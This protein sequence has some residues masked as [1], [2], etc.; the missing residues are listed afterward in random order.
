MLVGAAAALLT[1]ARKDPRGAC[2][3]VGPLRSF[4][5]PRK[6]PPVA[7]ALA[8]ETVRTMC[9]ADVLD[10][11]AAFKV[12]VDSAKKDESG[13]PPPKEG[14]SGGRARLLGA[15]G[16]TRRR[17]RRLR[18]RSPAPRGSARVWAPGGSNDDGTRE[19]AHEALARFD[20]EVL[21]CA[22]GDDRRRRR[23][24]TAR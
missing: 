6:A 8:L 3:L 5:D 4:L 19:A 16:W 13:G 11:Y 17:D 22:P 15:G 21:V 9:D 12:V 20:P 10:F 7:R 23:R 1:C 2:D 24:V 14:A 18:R